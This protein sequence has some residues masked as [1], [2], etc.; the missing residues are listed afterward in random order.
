MEAEFNCE[1]TDEIICP[2]CGHEFSDSFALF[3]DNVG[4]EAENSCGECNKI[5]ITTTNT[6]YLFSTRKLED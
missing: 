6:I 5:F 1:Y 4:E 2:Y 3:C